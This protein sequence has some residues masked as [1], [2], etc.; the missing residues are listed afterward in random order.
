MGRP[1]FWWV[2]GNGLDKFGSDTDKARSHPCQSL[3][4]RLA[5][6]RLGDNDGEF[7]NT[8][9]KD[10]SDWDTISWWKEASS[11]SLRDDASLQNGKAILPHLDKLGAGERADESHKETCFRHTPYCDEN[12]HDHKRDIEFI[13]TFRE[14]S[15]TIRLS[16]PHTHGE[17]ALLLLLLLILF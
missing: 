12:G 8:I 13:P 7:D 6:R 17:L 3:V 14:W 9:D 1:E 11:L 10:I 15:S 16:W 4:W 2:D 5:D